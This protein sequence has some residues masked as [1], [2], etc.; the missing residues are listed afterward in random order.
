[1]CIKTDCCLFAH[2]ESVKASERKEKIVHY[3]QAYESISNQ[4]AQGLT[5]AHRNTVTS[6]FRSLVAENIIQRTGTGKGARYILLESVLF[7]EEL[8]AHLWGNRDQQTLEK[9][10]S[11]EKR[12]KVFFDRTVDKALSAPFDFG[13]RVE[14]IF[15]DSLSSIK[16]KRRTLAQSER[17][18]KKERLVVDLAWASSRIEG[19]RYSL[20]ETEVLIKHNETTRGK[21]IDEARMI[22]NHKNALLYL[23]EQRQFSALA[24]HDIMELH[25]L[26]IDGLGVPTGFR[27]RLV[28]VS[29]S[30]YV[31]C[32]NEF[33]IVAT[34]DRIV[35]KINNLE[36]VLAKAVAANLLLAYLQPFEDGNKRTARMLGNA[37]M[38]SHDFLPISFSHT[39]KEEYIKSILYFYERQNPRYFMALFLKELNHSFRDYSE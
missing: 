1:M 35:E 19:N 23:R 38:M 29:N 30:S 7:A 27:K 24:R 25:Q 22:L 33:Q 12:R 26:L 3:L 8:V 16:A 39:P 28:Q 34:F 11:T 36:S 31:P 4:E 13:Q 10:F 37:L 20:L 14:D 18:R 15:Q 32:D 2:G 17:K 21:S 6:D 5:G 9:Y